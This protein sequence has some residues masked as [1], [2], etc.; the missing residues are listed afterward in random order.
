MT[1]GHEQPA[2]RFGAHTRSGSFSSA[3]GW[4]FVMNAGRQAMNLVITF[5]LASVL[6]PTAFG[7]VAMAL[8]YVGFA[9]LIV[10]Q[11][12]GAALIQREDLSRVHTNTGFAL[13]MS[14]T[15]VLTIA[16]LVGSEFWAS[17]NHE[18]QLGSVVR[19]L[20]PLL[21]LRALVVV[22][23]ALLRR[24][25]R[26]R[27][28]AFRTNVSVLVGG[29]AGLV[30]I[31]LGLGIWALV[32][33]Q[34][35]TGLLEMVIVWLA[36][37]WWPGRDVSWDAFRDLFPFSIRST[38][39]AFGVFANNR[40]DTVVVGLVLGPTVVGLFRFAA[41]L[42]DTVLDSISGAIRAV[43]LPEL[44]RLQSRPESLRLRVLS[45]VRFSSS[46]CFVPLAALAAA[47]PLAIEMLGDE[48]MPAVGAVGFLAVAGA[49]R[50]VGQ[51]TGPTLQAVGHP[52]RLAALTWGA[53]IISAGVL[54]LGTGAIRGWS[55]SAQ[56]MALAVIMCALHAGV[57]LVVNLLVL[58][59]T[60]GA[61]L[62]DLL[63][64]LAPG[65]AAGATGYVIGSAVGWMMS[66]LW[67]GLGLIGIGLS[68][69][70]VGTS[71]S[72]ALVPELKRPA[73][74]VVRRPRRPAG[75]T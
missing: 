70:A 31:A 39:A 61:R 40:L 37:R 59:H 48:W 68:A 34:L 53:A 28:L 2:E 36:A 1:S 4:A 27:A 55:T 9:Q 49:G 64:A 25:Q 23:D 43:S 46:V 18:P 52:G 10:Q 56:V 13:L 6:G 41:R 30:A 32:I 74:A 5:V 35:V 7:V 42:V 71:I 45:L 33:Q 65:V 73:S 47:A 57:F 22:P 21:L 51:L 24:Q 38:F 72:V 20:T 8:V 12:L 14:M 11:G 62:R 60:I 26:F 58:T 66:T 50:V 15:S 16:A 3:V 69:V 54:F 29:L 19:W 17:L 44:A 63:L 75:V 67:T